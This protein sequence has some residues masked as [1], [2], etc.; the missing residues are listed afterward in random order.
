QVL[1]S[2]LGYYMNPL[3]NIVL[4]MTVLGERLGRWQWMSV[5]LALTGV[6]ISAIGGEGFPWIAVTLAFSFSFYGLIRKLIRVGP[7]VGLLVETMMLLPIA[8]GL[9]GWTMAVREVTFS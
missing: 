2:S 5:G 8:V 6:T 1:Q 7:M 9:I 4:G 3:V